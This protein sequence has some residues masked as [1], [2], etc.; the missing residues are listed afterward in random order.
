MPAPS[1]TFAFF[2]ERHM[3]CAPGAKSPRAVQRI[4]ESITCYQCSRGV[5]SV[6]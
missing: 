6:I 1:L 5:L 2:E 4:R 3:I